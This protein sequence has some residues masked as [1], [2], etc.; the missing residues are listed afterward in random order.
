MQEIT[1]LSPPVVR[2]KTKTP[3]T[4]TTNTIATNIELRNDYYSHKNATYHHQKGVFP[5]CAP[6]KQGEQVAFPLAQSSRLA[7]ALFLTHHPPAP[8]PVEDTWFI[9][10]WPRHQNMSTSP[11]PTSPPPASLPVLDIPTIIISKK[12]VR[13]H[14]YSQHNVCAKFSGND[15]RLRASQLDSDDRLPLAVKK[16]NSK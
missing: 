5:V 3:T 4:T 9:V 2:G 13:S 12:D 8:F 14:I 6:E 10:S 1:H 16:E 7:I 15:D 11:S